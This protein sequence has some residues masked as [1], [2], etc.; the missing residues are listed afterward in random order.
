MAGRAK[1]VSFGAYN[2]KVQFLCELHVRA[3]R[4]K[5]M[6]GRFTDFLI[7]SR[8]YNTNRPVNGN[9]PFCPS[10]L[11][12]RSQTFQNCSPTDSEKQT[13]TRSIQMANLHEIDNRSTK[14]TRQI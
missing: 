14:N 4:S 5:S 12:T 13:G 1:T 2:S 11:A 9:V 10:K 8:S 7:E 3:A 6:S